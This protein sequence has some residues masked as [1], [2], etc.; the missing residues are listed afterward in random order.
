MHIDELLDLQ[1][2]SSRECI[3]SLIVTCWRRYRDAARLIG[4]P[5][6]AAVDLEEWGY[7][8]IDLSP[9]VAVYDAMC[10]RYIDELFSGQEPLFDSLDDAPGARWT[11]YFHHRLIPCLSVE[12]EFARNI[13]RAAGCLQC[14]KP[15]KA[16]ECLVHH[17]SEM[18]LPK[19][20]FE[21][22]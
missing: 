3:H 20:Q 12:D 14:Q 19:E 16:V 5:G 2:T 22:R 18:T 7:K 15:S 9:L 1:R 13:L 21:T 11:R 10:R 8:S 6:P 17:I 4:T